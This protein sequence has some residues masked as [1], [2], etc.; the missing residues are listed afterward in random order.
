MSAQATS[1]V[2]ASEDT[3][4]LHDALP[5]CFQSDRLLIKGGRMVT[6]DQSFCADIYKEDGLIK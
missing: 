5:I 6:G 3:L 4:S 1:G 2:Y